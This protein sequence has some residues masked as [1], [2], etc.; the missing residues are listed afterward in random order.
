MKKLEWDE[1][2]ERNLPVNM[3]TL[4]RFKYQ[5]HDWIVAW[6]SFAARV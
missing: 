5:D 1:A 4:G 6:P 3:I 2:D